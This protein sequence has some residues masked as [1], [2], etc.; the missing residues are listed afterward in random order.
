MGPKQAE[1]AAPR[2]RHR[3]SFC[4]V[5]WP[6]APARATEDCRSS[7]AELLARQ[8]FDPARW[9][10]EDDA[11]FLHPRDDGKVAQAVAVTYMG[12]GRQRGLR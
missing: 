7:A 10:G 1:E 4:F 3:R 2:D 9:V 12:D 6:V 11:I 5:E 8:L